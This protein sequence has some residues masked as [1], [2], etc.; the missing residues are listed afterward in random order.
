MLMYRR[1]SSVLPWYAACQSALRFSSCQGW[2][3]TRV[4]VARARRALPSPNAAER[5]ARA[6]VARVPHRVVFG[7]QLSWPELRQ[8]ARDLRLT[9]RDLRLTPRLGLG[10]G[11]TPRLGRIMHDYYCRGAL[12]RVG[13]LPRFWF[14]P[15][16]PLIFVQNRVEFGV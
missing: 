8:V 11:L 10:L 3:T 4:R 14:T 7:L 2:R 6:R 16:F 5:R 1:T 13:S 9:P 15:P 12:F